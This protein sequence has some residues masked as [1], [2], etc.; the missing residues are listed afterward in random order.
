MNE[1][2]SLIRFSIIVPVRDDP[3]LARCLEG[4]AAQC[5]EPEAYEV[6]VIGDGA[7]TAA[8]H[9][10][11][12]HRA[13]YVAQPAGGAY[14]ARN[15]GIA[16]AIG[17]IL[18]FTDSDCWHPP[19]WLASIGSV[20]ERERCGAVTGPARALNN[21][22]VGLLV[23]E[24]DDARWARL[25]AEGAGTYSDTRNLAGPRSLFLREPFDPS[26]Q[27]AGDLDWGIR[28]S[29]QGSPIRY[30]EEIAVR[31]ANV[32]SL[33]EVWRRGVRRGRGLAR[34]RDKHGWRARISGSRR[35]G[36]LGIDVKERLLAMGAHPVARPI[37][38][39][40]AGAV[41]GALAVV[42]AI[43][44]H[45]PGLRGLAR[46]PFEWLDRASLLLG[47]LIGPHHPA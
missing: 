27:H 35:L 40:A 12:A 31:H 22:P 26:F 25:I 18:V 3:R 46:R 2:K 38:V 5:V 41:T 15:R 1:H 29:A 17:D 11:A 9:I 44:L 33:R 36:L 28:M 42:V 21:D 7:S 23:Q 19:Q 16:E 14:A 47:I 39:A 24:I 4:L 30:V 8:Q 20:L 13:R 32:T 6:L 34:I 37:M 43:L 10:A 45:L